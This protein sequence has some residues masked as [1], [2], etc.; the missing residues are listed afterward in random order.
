LGFSQDSRPDERREC[1]GRHEF[2]RLPET[3]FEQIR[4]GQEMLKRLGAR[5]ELHEHVDITIRAGLTAQN[6]AEQRQ[7]LNP[8]ASDLYLRGD[9]TPHSLVS[10]KRL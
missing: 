3:R 2:H 1:L 6:R 4:Q 10:T 5:R 8:E 9:Q 7:A